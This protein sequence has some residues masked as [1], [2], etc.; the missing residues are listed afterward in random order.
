MAGMVAL[1]ALSFR[2]IDSDGDTEKQYL[3]GEVLLEKGIFKSLLNSHKTMLCVPVC[4]NKLT[5]LPT[6]VIQAIDRENDENF[7]EFDEESLNM[8][9]GE[10][11]LVFKNKAVELRELQIHAAE[12]SAMDTDDPDLRLSF[13]REYG[14]GTGS[15]LPP[16]L[17]Q[18]NGSRSLLNH[19]DKLVFVDFAKLNSSQKSADNNKPGIVRQTSAKRYSRRTSMLSPAD[20]DSMLSDHNLDPFIIEDDELVYLAGKML[21]SYGLIERYNIV[22]D[23]LRLFFQTVRNNYHDPAFHNFK[24]GWGT[25]HLTYQILRHGIDAK[26]SPVEIFAVLIGAICHDLDHPGNN[27]AF[28]V[29]TRSDRSTLYGDDTVLERHHLAT[30]LMILSTTCRAVLGDMSPEDVDIFRKTIIAGIMATDMARHFTQVEYLHQW[31]LLMTS[32][33]ELHCNIF[34]NCAERLKLAGVILHCADIGAQTQSTAVSLKWSE[35]VLVEFRAQAEKEKELGLP[36]TPFM[37]GLDDELTC[38]QLQQGMFKS[39]NL[40]LTRVLRAQHVL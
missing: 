2:D 20:V 13:L 30:A 26:L 8:V 32:S 39:L 27:N 18:T 22:G 23:E 25:L 15:G 4:I 10:L 19:Q 3:G 21:D 12:R 24:H 29:A 37:Q 9:A 38:M 17:R 35:A 36:M 6:A 33:T 14:L 1:K 34:N 31:Q 7:D 16:L 5:G 11:S 28:E 40:S